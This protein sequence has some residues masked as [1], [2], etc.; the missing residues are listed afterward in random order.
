M[1]KKE[2]THIRNSFKYI[3]TVFAVLCTWVSQTAAAQQPA[4]MPVV[5]NFAPSAYHGGLQNWSCTQGTDGRM[6][7]GNNNGLLCY[8]GY[9]WTLTPLP[10]LGTVRSVLADGNRIY[11]GG[12]TDF[13]YFERD[14]F[15][16]MV[17]TS[18][19]PANYRP[20]N[21]EIWNITKTADGRIVFQSFCSWFEYNGHKITAH[22]N[23]NFLPLWFFNVN[24]NIY[25]QRVYGGLYLLQNA[26]YK[27]IVDRKAVGDDDIVAVLP[28]RDHALLLATQRSGIYVLNKGRVARWH[29]AIDAELQQALVNH[30]VKIS[31]KTLVVGTIKNGIYAVDLATCSLLWHYNH[32]Q[33]LNNNTVLNLSTDNSGNVW[34]ALDNGAAVIHTGMPLTIM[35][36]GNIGMVYG[37]C[38]LNSNMY[39]STNQNVWLYRPAAALAPVSGTEGQNWFVARFGS[40]ILAGNNAGTM[41]VN[42]TTAH[43]LPSPQNG[44]TMMRSY[45][46]YG[47]DVLLESSY[48]E[49]RVYA[50]RDGQWNFS[51]VVKGFSAPIREFEIDSRGVIWAAHF[52]KGVYRVELSKDLLK[53]TAVKYFGSLEKEM[54]EGRMHVTA[55][56]GRVVFAAGKN[57]YAYDDMHK[58]IV[59]YKALESIMQGGIIS[60]ANVDNSTFWVSNEDGFV[61]ISEKGNRYV[62]K[63]YLPETMFGRECNTSGPSMYV[64]GDKTYFFLND[65]IGRYLNNSRPEALPPYPL[66]IASAYS[67]DKNNKKTLLPCHNSTGTRIKTFGNV[68]FKLSF[69]NYNHQKYIYI[70]HLQGGGVDLK[71]TSNNPKAVFNNLDYGNYTFNAKVTTMDGRKISALTYHFSRLRPWWLSVWAWMAYIAVAMYAMYL[72]NRWRTNRIVERNRKMA[73]KAL[74]EE[75]LKTLEKERIIARQQKQLLENELQA[76]GKEVASMAFDTM[77]MKNN[78]D[79]I[80]EALQEGERQGTI[81]PHNVEKILKLMNEGDKAE[82]WEVFKNNF[83]LI[84]KKFFRNLHQRYP[85]LTPTDLRFCALLRLNLN[86]KDIA[87]FTNLTIRG[88]EGARYRLRKKLGI[89]Q[90]K[91]LT[92]F[93]IEFE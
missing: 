80:R 26:T 4:F 69:P 3:A 78:V 60:A 30:A 33:G 50:K 76:K 67:Y 31:P 10:N 89:P 45:R 24:G 55:I 64:Q 74:M 54:P 1:V 36:A 7:F 16:R 90:D 72:Y 32:N 73:E 6:Y 59:R 43:P 77:V 70:F 84:H 18:L 56:A 57:I 75:R 87:N 13:G 61:L 15:G 71:S 44:S 63:V 68:S 9:E 86:T 28:A 83:D 46:Y 42:G 17:Y 23:K 82:F 48:N 62:P 47:H 37:L 66:T 22:Y 53:A 41:A 40:N 39:I 25:V 38:A 91:S 93:L 79:S 12:Y 35:R 5:T 81:S 29:T 21:D 85:N 19:W 92:D 27:S 2:T 8:D 88:V 52:S 20:H 51:H 11:A 34:A 65:G 14:A 58:R 49:L